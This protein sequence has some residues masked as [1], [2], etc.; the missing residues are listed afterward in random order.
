MIK[1]LIQ[2]GNR[3]EAVFHEVINVFLRGTVAGVGGVHAGKE[4][5]LKIGLNLGFL[6]TVESEVE[7]L[8]AIVA[9]LS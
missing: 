7:I 5:K 8:H 4:G 6:L 9:W 2:E 3:D 1:V